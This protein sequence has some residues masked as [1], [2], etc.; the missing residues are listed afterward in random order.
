MEDSEY[1]KFLKESYE[2]QINSLKKTVEDQ[3]TS[4]ENLINLLEKHQAQQLQQQEKQNDLYE[5][6]IES[7]D[8]TIETLE[9][10]INS[11]KTLI[12]QKNNIIQ[13]NQY[14]SNTNQQHL[15]SGDNVGKNKNYN[16]I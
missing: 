13:I 3:K 11:L 1:L 15:G 9:K 12:D 8:F 10:E 4:Y 6:I 5:R 16:N 7:K 2:N 14:N